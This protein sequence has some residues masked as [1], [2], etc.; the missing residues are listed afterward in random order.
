MKISLRQTTLL[1]SEILDQ[2]ISLEL[3]LACLYNNELSFDPLLVPSS[4]VKITKDLTYST[5]APITIELPP[6]ELDLLGCNTSLLPD[7]ST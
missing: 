5:H 2:Y 6:F 4:P 3:D 7:E 1:G